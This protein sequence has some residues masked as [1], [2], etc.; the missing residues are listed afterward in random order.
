VDDTRC[1]KH[2]RGEGVSPSEDAVAMWGVSVQQ[3]K[4]GTGGTR[5]E[6]HQ[7]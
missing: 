4:C 3:R 5:N 2:A 1:E 6:D 7:E